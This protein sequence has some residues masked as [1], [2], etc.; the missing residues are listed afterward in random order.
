MSREGR[1]SLPITRV[2]PSGSQK[3]QSV[4]SVKPA[5]I[6]SAVVGSALPE[7]AAKVEMVAGSFDGVEIGDIEDRRSGDGKERIGDGEW[8]GGVAELCLDRAIIGALAALGMHHA[9]VLE[10]EDGDD[11]EVVHACLHNCVIARLD[12]AIQQPRHPRMI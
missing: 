1:L 5:S 4:T 8:V 11:G 7:I 12:R 10:I 2:A 9:S 3:A 6:H